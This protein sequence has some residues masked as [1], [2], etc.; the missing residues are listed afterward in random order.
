MSSDTFLHPPEKT[1]R[2]V[3]HDG[4]FLG[5]GSGMEGSQVLVESRRVSVSVSVF[6]FVSVAV[7]KFESSES[8][9]ES[10]S[11]SESWSESASSSGT[12]LKSLSEVATTSLMETLN[13]GLV[14]SVMPA[15]LSASICGSGRNKGTTVLQPGVGSLVRV[16]AVGGDFNLGNTAEGEQE[17]YEV[18]GRLFRSLFH[19]VGDRVG[20]R[21]LEH[22]AFGLEAG[23]VHTHELTGLEHG[24]L[25]KIL[26]PRVVKCKPFPAQRALNSWLDRLRRII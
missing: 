3:C 23:K 6:I 22:D 18:P 21:G 8:M 15:A 2:T 19:N 11:R 24:S 20:D 17:L 26:P 16:D 25:A 10:G 13:G 5:S 7:S 1:A 12:R 4:F 14:G 9:S